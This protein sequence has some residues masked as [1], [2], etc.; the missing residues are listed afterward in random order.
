[1]GG[2]VLVV[3]LQVPVASLR[4]GL[5]TDLGEAGVSRGKDGLGTG[6][7]ADERLQGGGGEVQSGP[8]GWRDGG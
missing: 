7:D 8:R 4:R 5:P 2:K 1:M 6:E 3:Q